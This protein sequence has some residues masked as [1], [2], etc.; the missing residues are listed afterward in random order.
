MFLP[1][2]LFC[3]VFFGG[4]LAIIVI[5]KLRQVRAA[6]KWP[7]VTGHILSATASG[8]T[9]TTSHAKEDGET[10]MTEVRNFA[11]IAYRY[12]VEGRNYTGKRISI[13]EDLGNDDVAGKLKRYPKGQI[14]EVFYDPADPATAVLERN[15]PEGCARAGLIGLALVLAVVA[16]FGF[17]LDHAGALIAP[18]I[19]PGNDASSVIFA[20]TFAA[21]AT[22][23]AVALWNQG[24]AARR[25]QRTQGRTEAGRSSNITYRYE[26]GGVS[27]SS[28]TV[29]FGQPQRSIYKLPSGTTIR[30][31]T[32]GQSV[33]VFYNPAD[34]TKSCL[35]PRASGLWLPVVAAVFTAGLAW[36][37]ATQ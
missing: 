12:Q 35:A 29:V 15:L 16:I 1:I 3:V 14:V 26:I 32:P 11:R 6:S 21:L 20:A 37:L 8:G 27:Y 18:Y 34:P 25:W 30:G 9:V 22:V 19:K 17:G 33:T 23:F 28:D 4:F 10:D 13:G 31:N 2:V 36:F 7:S 24:R 5:K